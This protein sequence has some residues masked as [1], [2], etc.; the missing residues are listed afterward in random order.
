MY[1][2][3]LWKKGAAKI[4]R[5]NGGSWFAELVGSQMKSYKTVST[6]KL[7][8]GCIV[9]VLEALPEDYIDVIL[10]KGSI[11]RSWVYSDISKISDIPDILDQERE[12]ICKWFEKNVNEAPF[13]IPRARQLQTSREKALPSRKA[14]PHISGRLMGSCLI[15]D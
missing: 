10:D 3:R 14:P 2:V 4:T 7:I 5:F 1:T 12:K 15:G 9:E 8:N 11:T 6:F 13:Q